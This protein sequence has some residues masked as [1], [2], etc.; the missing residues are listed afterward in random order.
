MVLSVVYV[1]WFYRHVMV[2]F[3]VEDVPHGQVNKH[4]SIPAQFLYNWVFV[5]VSLIEH[6]RN[7]TKHRNAEL[8]AQVTTVIT[9]SYSLEQHL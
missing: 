6:T 1:V 9:Y 7:M 2:L 5:C 3:C 8:D 4:G